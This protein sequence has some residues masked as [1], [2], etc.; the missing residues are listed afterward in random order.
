M[1]GSAKSIVPT[2]TD[3]S[4]RGQKQMYIGFDAG[5]IYF[6]FCRL[7]VRH[8]KGLNVTPVGR[9]KPRDTVNVPTWTLLQF[10]SSVRHDENMNQQLW[11]L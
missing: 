6:K 5:F 7:S 1:K 9:C 10:L 11:Y 4:S 3:S 2:I 8:A